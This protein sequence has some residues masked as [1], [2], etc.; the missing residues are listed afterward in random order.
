VLCLFILVEVIEV[1]LSCLT[2]S[3]LCT[4]ICHVMVPKLV[5]CTYHAC[6]GELDVS[7][8]SL[9]DAFLDTEYLG[10]LVTTV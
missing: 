6:I 2:V 3:K 7:M 5:K 1:L 9:P 10:T 4:F 8:V